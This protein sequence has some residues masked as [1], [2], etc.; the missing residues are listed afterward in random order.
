VKVWTF[1]R[2]HVER[3]RTQELAGGGWGG[4]GRRGEADEG[5]TRARPATV[6]RCGSEEE[7][8]WLEPGASVEGSDREL[9]NEWNTHGGCWGWSSPFIGAG[10]A[11]GGD[12]GR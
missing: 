9:G 5:L 6:K 7:Q 3:Y 11:Q 1:T 2:R 10:G 8:R 4:S 12:N